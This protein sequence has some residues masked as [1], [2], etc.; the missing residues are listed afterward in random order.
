M[1]S[2]KNKVSAV[3]ALFVAASFYVMVSFFDANNFKIDNLQANVLGEVVPIESTD[4]EDMAVEIGNV[5]IV[6][7]ELSNPFSDVAD[8]H[9]QLSVMV[10]LYYR[11][12]I[13]DVLSSE[14]RPDDF[15]NRA[16]FV[17]VV[18]ESINYNYI[19]AALKE[20]CFSD[21][22]LV[23]HDW[24]A[25]QVCAAYGEGFIGG[26]GTEFRP[27]QAITRAEALKVLF[28]AYNVNYQDFVAVTAPFD[29]VQEGD[30]FFGVATAAK[31][32]GLISQS[33]FQANENITR[34]EF[35]GHLHALLF[36]KEL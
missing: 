12:L 16:E 26:Y 30:W 3:I 24:F 11:G 28:E 25:A 21:V 9:P 34:A 33:M 18:M 32:H 10:D 1:A 35:F 15:V 22:N 6:A 17:K 5:P 27:S 13:G 29:D 36:L 7:D 31:N 19:E 4:L 20:S 2:H 23:E 8:D 14:I